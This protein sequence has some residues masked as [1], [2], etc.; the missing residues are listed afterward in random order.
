MERT[1]EWP[2]ICNNN[3]DFKQVQLRLDEF[4]LPRLYF[5]RNC[6]YYNGFCDRRRNTGRNTY[7]SAQ[8]MYSN[9]IRTVFYLGKQLLCS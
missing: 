6:G 2:V 4:I 9:F 8:I 5:W 3:V 7:S 1:V